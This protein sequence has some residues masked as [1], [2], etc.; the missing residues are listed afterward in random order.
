MKWREI[1]EAQHAVI[2]R[3]QL[4]A[5]GMS[6]AVAARAVEA[7]ELEP[8]SRRV[9]RLVGSPRTDHQRLMAAVLDAGPG[10]VA[11]HAS[12]AWLLGLPGFGLRP[13]EV[14]RPRTG[15]RWPSSLAVVH[16][17][18][19][20]PAAHV[21]CVR[22]IP[23]TTAERTLCDLAWSFHPRRVE[24]AVDTALA[25]RKA[26]LARLWLVHGDLAARGR[27]GRAAM[28]A[29]LEVRPPG[30]IAPESD[31]EDLFLRV[32]RT[33]GVREPARQVD[34]GAGEWI[35]RVDFLYREARL[36]IELDGRLGHSSLLD[37]QH[38]AERDEAL[39]AAGFDVAR[40]TW[41]DVVLHPYRMLNRVRPAA[42]ATSPATSPA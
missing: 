19:L 39:R 6:R 21:T 28:A 22:S 8:F 24:R 15:P 1:A 7:G 17:P 4:R 3:W 27:P 42:S 41:A 9:L 23:V 18:R 34:L 38:D 31:L 2:G 29:I 11:S 35:G 26:D 12:A 10:A 5:A 40:F 25:S 37:R 32:L 16:H 30:Y 13:L 14:S 33:H 36:V 20:L